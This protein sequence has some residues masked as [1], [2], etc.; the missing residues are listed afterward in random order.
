MKNITSLRASL[1]IV[2]GL[3][4]SM[5]DVIFIASLELVAHGHVAA[6]VGISRTF[7]EMSNIASV[8]WTVFEGRLGFYIFYLAR[9]PRL[10]FELENN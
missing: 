2:E 3:L 6:G 5:I 7:F 8:S 4:F 10:W 9:A 1:R